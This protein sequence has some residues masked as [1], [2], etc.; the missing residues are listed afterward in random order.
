LIAILIPALLMLSPHWP[1]VED[2]L[3]IAGT[4]LSNCSSLLA[5]ATRCTLLASLFSPHSVL[6]YKTSPG[7][8]AE[9]L[10]SIFLAL[11]HCLQREKEN[12]TNLRQESTDNKEKTKNG[13]EGTNRTDVLKLLADILKRIPIAQQM[14]END[15][16]DGNNI[17]NMDTEDWCSY[18]EKKV[19]EVF[20]N[21]LPSLI[22]SIVLV[23]YPPDYFIFL[24]TNPTGKRNIRACVVKL[25]GEIAEVFGQSAK[26][27]RRA[28]CP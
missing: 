20:G 18:V 16:N 27:S 23:H 10:A 7:C 25:F 8:I 21:S 1:K 14:T 9:A 22:E 15:S 2:N 13:T 19:L 12:I 6:L 3:T 4:Q 24:I 5:Y 26:W 17:P 11:L 28:S